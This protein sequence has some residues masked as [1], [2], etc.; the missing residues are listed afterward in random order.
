MKNIYSYNPVV[1]AYTEYPENNGKNR[2]W[3]RQSDHYEEIHA[4]WGGYKKPPK[5][6]GQAGFQRIEKKKE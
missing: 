2:G 6:G 5:I 3:F 4:S 1:G